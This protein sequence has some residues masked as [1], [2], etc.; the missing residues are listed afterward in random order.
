MTREEINQYLVEYKDESGL[1]LP[2]LG[3]CWHEK[4]NRSWF[5]PYT[6]TI[7]Y[8]CGKCVAAFKNN[9]DLHN[10]TGFGLLWEAMRKREDWLAFSDPHYGAFSQYP[11]ECDVVNPE[12]F[13]ALVVEYLKE[14]T[15]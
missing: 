7:K 5:N 11:Y 12:T 6:E 2:S 10:W 4:G 1:L 3:G 15:S 8:E 9:T 13:P 14:R